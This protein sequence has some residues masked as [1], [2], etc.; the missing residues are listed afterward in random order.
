LAKKKVVKFAKVAEPVELTIERFEMRLKAAIARKL[1]SPIGFKYFYELVYNTDLPAHAMEW[2]ETVYR[3]K[4]NDRGSLIFAFRGSWKT[5]VITLAFGAYRIGQEPHRANLIIQANDDSAAKS[6]SAI[7]DVIEHNNGWKMVFPYVVPDKP[8]GWGSQ[9]YE[10]KDTRMPYG[11][12]R[13]KNASRK[14]PTLMGVGYKS[15]SA[16]GKHPD[17]F[18]AIDDIHDEENTGSAK[19]RQHVINRVTGTILPMAV[20]DETKRAGQRLITWEIVVGTPWTEDDCYHYL[21]DTG[22][23][24]FHETP[25]MEAAQIGEEGA[26]EIGD[27]DMTSSNHTD[28]AGWWKLKW[29]ERFSKRIIVSWRNKSGK[30]EFFRMYMLDL[31]SSFETGLKYFLFPSERIDPRWVSGGGM[32]YASVSETK[33]VEIKG[34]NYMA[35]AY[36]LKIPTGGAVIFDGVFQQCTQGQTEAHME[37]AQ[38]LFPNWQGCVVE[39]DGRGDE[40]IQFASRHPHLRI[41]PMMTKGKGKK[42]RLERQLAPWLE[43]GMLRISDANTPFLTA[44]R[45]ALDEYPNWHLDPIDAVYWYARSIPDVLQIKS[46]EDELPQTRPERRRSSPFARLGTV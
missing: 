39:A 36:G 40:F 28:I 30:R 45:K 20:E 13:Q 42:E 5:S 7:A 35:L 38:G 37:K 17:G 23:F 26:V 27:E 3:A 6:A 1:D 11:S 43:N 24:V 9:G 12:W 19:E 2:I 29:P 33:Q 31:R 22:E 46:P 15:S 21:K 16:I 10:V 25:V 34:R 14:D 41:M 32:D 8:K 44:L 4:R 18:L